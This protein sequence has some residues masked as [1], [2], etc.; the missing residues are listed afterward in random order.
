[1]LRVCVW[2]VRQKISVRGNH[3][4]LVNTVR[5]AKKLSNG[6]AITVIPRFPR[7]GPAGLSCIIHQLR[8]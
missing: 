8:A 4:M 5:Y 2:A 3:S 1:M 7:G 6:Y